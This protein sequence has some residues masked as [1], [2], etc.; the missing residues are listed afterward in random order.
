MVYCCSSWQSHA[1]YGCLAFVL[2]ISLLGKGK[3]SSMN[4]VDKVIQLLKKGELAEA[5]SHINRINI[6]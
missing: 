1:N 2:V 4:S 3:E 5:H 6:K